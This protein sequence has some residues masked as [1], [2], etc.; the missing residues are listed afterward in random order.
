M[1]ERKAK[2]KETVGRFDHFGKPEYILQ[3]LIFCADCGKTLCYILLP[4]VSG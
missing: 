1:D 2:Y 4:F 3:G